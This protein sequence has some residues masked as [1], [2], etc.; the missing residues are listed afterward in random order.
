MR[1]LP[2]LPERRDRVFIGVIAVISLAEHERHAVGGGE[3][4]RGPS[5][6]V[7]DAGFV[8]RGSK[9]SN[10][11]QEGIADQLQIVRLG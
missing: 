10:G 7:A 11:I 9:G 1:K 8:P 6:D 5:N 4:A 3:L 2:A